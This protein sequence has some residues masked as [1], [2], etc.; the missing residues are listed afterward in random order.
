[1]V[2]IELFYNISVNHK[3]LSYAF[4]INKLCALCVSVANGKY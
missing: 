2:L 3:M 4:K 1:M